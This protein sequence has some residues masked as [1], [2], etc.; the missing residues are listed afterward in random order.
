MM[1]MGRIAW[2]LAAG[3]CGWSAGGLCLREAGRL[4][5]GDAGSAGLPRVRLVCAIGWVAL[6]GAYG[7]TLEAVELCL[8]C[9]VLVTLS[10]TDRA[11]RVIP[12]ACTLAAVALRAVYLACRAV[13]D[14]PVAASLAARSV[15]GAVAVVAV[16]LMLA[17]VLDRVLGQESMG[18][19]DLKLF[20]V[21]GLYL[22]WQACLVVVPLACVLGLL[23]ELVRHRGLSRE[24]FAF[25]PAIACSL[26]LVL[27]LVG[28]VR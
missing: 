13:V 10:L 16:L 23:G 17:L 25:G 27:V 8:L 4:L 19:G 9:L 28:M 12:D 15:L 3:L 22:G 5:G 21:A 7:A 26:W 18:G 6:A 2:A 1:G 14:A 24:P 11:A 20:G